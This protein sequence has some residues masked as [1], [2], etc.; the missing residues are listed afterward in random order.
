[1]SAQEML[2]VLNSGSTWKYAACTMPQGKES[3]KEVSTSTKMSYQ[4]MRLKEYFTCMLGFKT[5]RPSGVPGSGRATHR[6]MFVSN[7]KI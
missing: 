6:R 7:R 1:M 2:L 3:E 5:C 4:L